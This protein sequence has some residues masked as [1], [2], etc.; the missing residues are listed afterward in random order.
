MPTPRCVRRSVAALDAFVDWVGCRF[1]GL[2]E[3]ANIVERQPQHFGQRSHRQSP[4]AS[5][6][7]DDADAGFAAVRVPED[8]HV[9]P[10]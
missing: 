3:C 2:D 1:G 4:P 8:L 9:R 5:V 10:V 7:A 6:I